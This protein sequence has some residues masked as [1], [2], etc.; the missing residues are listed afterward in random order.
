[1]KNLQ[2]F[3]KKIS[4][5]RKVL[6][7][8]ISENIQKV[9]SF[10][11]NENPFKLLMAFA[12]KNF[13]NN[14]EIY[15]VNPQRIE[16]TSQEQFVEYVQSIVTGIDTFSFD[17]NLTEEDYIKIFNLTKEI[18]EKIILYFQT[19]LKEHQKKKFKQKI[20][21]ESIRRYLFVRGDSIFEHHM[22]LIKIIFQDYN[23]FFKKHYN[24]NINQILEIFINIGSQI[25]ANI[26][27]NMIF[28]SKLKLYQ[29]KIS[30]ILQIDLKDLKLNSEEIIKKYQEIIA[31]AE[32]DIEFEESFRNFS[33][34][35]FKISPNQK[36]PAQF[37]DLLSANMGE[38]KDFVTFKKSPAF[39]TN[40]TIITQRPLIRHNG[41]SL[42]GNGSLFKSLINGRS[43]LFIILPLFLYD[44]PFI[45]VFD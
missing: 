30:S 18:F 7:P 38:N 27:N 15:S 40:N 29:T 37:L 23:P 20:R 2:D 41:E 12:L 22:E 28:L 9:I 5:L 26:Q 36:I 1:M 16:H 32:K 44:I 34:N 11:S 25:Q 33:E 21:V 43:G 8:E 31:E 42:A 13:Y 14:L 35:P 17:K 19:E 6:K 39:P 24:L 45:F 10:I 3:K 4:E